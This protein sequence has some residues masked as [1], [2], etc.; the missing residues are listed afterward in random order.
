MQL[1]RHPQTLVRP[2]VEGAFDE[3]SAGKRALRDEDAFMAV[4]MRLFDSDERSLALRLERLRDELPEGCT[5]TTFTYWYTSR[6]PMLEAV[7]LSG[8]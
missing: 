7:V 2:L 8:D 6:P 5:V 3:R 1:R 4:L